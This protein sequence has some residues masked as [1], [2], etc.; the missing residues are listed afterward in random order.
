MSEQTVSVKMN[1]QG[2]NIIIAYV[3]WWFLGWAGVHRFYLGRIKTG[4][5]QLA[6]TVIGWATIIFIIGYLFILAWFI[7]WALDAYYVYK[8]VGEENEKLGL[9][10]SSISLTKSGTVQNELEVLEQLHRLKEKGILTE[11]EYNA[12]KA[13]LVK[14]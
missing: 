10:R 11:D 12:K 4:V 14:A 8:I 7:W 9:D 5:G 3:L 6:L 2:K 13:E 1:V